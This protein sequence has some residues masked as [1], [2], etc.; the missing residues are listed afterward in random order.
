MESN[1]DDMKEDEDREAKQTH[2]RDVDYGPYVLYRC[3][4]V[5]FVGG[6][7]FGTLRKISNTNITISLLTCIR[8]SHLNFLFYINQPSF[9][10]FYSQSPLPFLFPTKNETK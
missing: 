1:T 5:V 2:D 3:C 6:M 4:A 9:P 10:N 8:I 7:I